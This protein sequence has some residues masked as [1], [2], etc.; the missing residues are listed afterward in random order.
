M[1]CCVAKPLAL[2]KYFK[3]IVFIFGT[4]TFPPGCLSIVVPHPIT[5]FPSPKARIEI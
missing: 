3:L 1:N 4:T 2:M 5:I